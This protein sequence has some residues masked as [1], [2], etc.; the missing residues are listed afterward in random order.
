M[1]FSIT[2]H[3]II[4]YQFITETAL[5]G[6]PVLMKMLH[7]IVG[8]IEILTII[9]SILGLFILYIRRNLWQWTKVTYTDEGESGSNIENYSN[10]QKLAH[11]L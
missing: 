10:S 9:Y 11:A 5:F 6:V 3:I 4:L 7:L 2:Q 8:L 1:P